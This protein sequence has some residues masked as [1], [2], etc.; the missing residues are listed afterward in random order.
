MI[1]FFIYLIINTLRD[2]FL[3][4]FCLKNTLQITLYEKLVFAGS[5]V[6]IAARTKGSL[7]GRVADRSFKKKG[8]FV[9]G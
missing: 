8:I 5:S 7:C 1:L 2:L 9:F 6:D 3:Y 4:K